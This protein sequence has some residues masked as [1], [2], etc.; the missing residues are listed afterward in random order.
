MLPTLPAVMTALAALIVVVAL[1]LLLGRLAHAGVLVRRAAGGRR[2][3]LRES[4]ALDNRRRLHLIA[5]D[6]Q[7]MLLLT[8]GGADCVVAVLRTGSVP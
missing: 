7:E 1:V 6:G 2:I 8:G 3:V 5:C 4:L